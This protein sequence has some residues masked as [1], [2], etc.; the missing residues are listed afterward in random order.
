M[1]QLS[2]RQ[3]NIDSDLDFKD[4]HKLFKVDGLELTDPENPTSGRT[5]LLTVDGDNNLVAVDNNSNIE[6]ILFANNAGALQL[7]DNAADQVAAQVTLEQL[8]SPTAAGIRDNDLVI[9]NS[10]VSRGWENITRTKLFLDGLNEIAG[11]ATSGVLTMNGVND[12]SF[13]ISSGNAAELTGVGDVTVTPV[14][15]HVVVSADDPGSAPATAQWVSRQLNLQDLTNFEGISTDGVNETK[16][17]KW[18]GP[19]TK[20]ILA[21]EAGSG[22]VTGSIDL[23]SDY[24]FS[25]TAVETADKPWIKFVGGGIQLGKNTAAPVNG[26]ILPNVAP[27]TDGMVLISTTSGSD[28]IM[29]FSSLSTQVD[30]SVATYLGTKNLIIPNL[31]ASNTGST[32]TGIKLTPTAIE[33]SG[34][35]DALLF[36]IGTQTPS[37]NDVLVMG[38]NSILDYSNRK[39]LVENALN[40]FSNAGSGRI[41]AYT[42]IG[43]KWETLKDINTLTL[44]DVVDKGSGVLNQIV[45]FTRNDADFV[46]TVRI[47]A[48][49]VKNGMTALFVGGGHWPLVLQPIPTTF[50]VSEPAPGAQPPDGT[51]CVTPN[52]NIYVYFD[53]WKQ[54]NGGAIEDGW[55]KLAWY[56]E[57]FP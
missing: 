3:L 54:F 48:S 4:M 36:K 5:L 38:S 34:A 27:S 13:E 25:S 24:L 12:Y 39:T 30:N 22:N 31:I 9:R 47:Q 18:T 55:R 29:S 41:L 21:D 20:W 45:S 16:V 53:F 23:A 8:V 6:T 40:E 11:T 15:K 28:K 19:V 56:D 57:V 50:P 1:V 14:A 7:T 32:K 33:F 35:S 52:S 42:N 49:T 17:L 44:Q 10:G 2:S 43:S 26:Y 37:L 46:N 51:V